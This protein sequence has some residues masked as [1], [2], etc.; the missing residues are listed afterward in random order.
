MI[1]RRLLMQKPVEKDDGWN[2]IMCKLNVT[3]TTA[4]TTCI[5][6]SFT[7][8]V[9]VS[10]ITFNEPDTKPQ[11]PFDTGFQFTWVGER[12]MYIHFK[13]GVTNLNSLFANV[14][15]VTYIDLNMLDTRYVRDMGGMCMGCTNLVQCL[16]SECRAD[17][18]TSTV[19]MFNSCSALKWADFGSYITGNFKPK[20][21]NDA[22]NMFNYCRA[23]TTI[24]LSMFDFSN[25]TMFGVMFGNCYALTEVYMNSPIRDDATISTNMF[26]NSS[27]ANAKLY[28]NGKKHDYSKIKAVLPSNWTLTNYNY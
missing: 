9:Q 19:N 16:M 3:T 1:R 21:I 18:L 12:V 22:R 7:G 27:A 2:Y 15:A 11:Y 5:S 20:L 14:T 13:E 17:S 6:T 4:R 8:S 26:T 23:I 24:N 10:H 25:C 28:Y